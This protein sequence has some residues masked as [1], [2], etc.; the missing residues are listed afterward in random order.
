[1]DTEFLDELAS[2]AP[3]PG[4]GG[5]SAVVGAVAASLASMVGELTLGK[6]RYADVEADVVGALG[7]LAILRARLVALVDEDAEAFAPLA[8]AYKMPAGTDEEQSTKSEALQDA[9]DGACEVP[10]SIM[11]A[12]V[13]V[14]HECD[15]L[16]QSGS[17]MAISDAG[18]CAVL[19]EAAIKAA[20]LNIFIN[21]SS[22]DDA[23]KAEEYRTR[24]EACIKM[25]EDLSGKIYQ[26]V[27]SEIGSTL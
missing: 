26:V 11:H 9:L 2:A 1:M 5:A 21:I 18:A 13:D 10:L 15:F 3:T 23:S 8:A 12:C 20:S 7:R 25:S 17:R 4:G 22:M 14:L 27:N 24:T 19:A 6:A 16:A